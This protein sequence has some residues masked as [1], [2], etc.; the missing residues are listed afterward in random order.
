MG[1]TYKEL[2]VEIKK[3]GY[4]WSGIGI[5][6]EKTGEHLVWVEP[7]D[8]L[9]R[10][11]QE[12]GSRKEITLEG[13]TW[14]VEDFADTPRIVLCG[15]GH[16]SKAVA[17]LAHMLEF[18]VIVMDERK[19]FVTKERFPYAK[20]RFVG[21]YASILDGLEENYNT[22]YIIM[23]PGHF[24]DRTSLRAC[25]SKASA[26]VGM[27]GSKSKVAYT[28]SEL[29]KE[30]VAKEALEKVYAPIGLEIGGQRPSEIAVSIF[31]QIIQLM[32]QRGTSS[33]EDE[34][35]EGFHQEEGVMACIVDS[36]GSSP[37]HVGTRM[38]IGKSGKQYG[39]IGGGAVENACIEQA[40]QMIATGQKIALEEYN[41]SRK[42]GATL[43]MV[44]GG[45][46][47]VWFETI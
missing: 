10:Q 41:L 25:L 24:K 45:H 3:Q 27:I 26:Y 29:V 30:G 36:K 28:F 8:E 33:L 42:E 14:Y 20:E 22:Y 7:K 4:V 5:A 38:M 13:T 35:K 32:N 15:G 21:D 46:I 39:T 34:I 1:F 47:K 18:D 44:C 16:V 11:L 6:G 17:Q 23:T 2:E 19:D 31:A 37:R 43:G 9:Q 12:A 40:K